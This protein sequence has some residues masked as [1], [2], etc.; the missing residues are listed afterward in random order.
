MLLY[1]TSTEFINSCN[2]FGNTAIQSFNDENT[3][4]LYIDKYF[5]ECTF[6]QRK[7]II[8]NKIFSYNEIKDF[9]IKEKLLVLI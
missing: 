6:V 9:L 4:L 2:Q 3:T 5:N 7:T 1:M 8:H